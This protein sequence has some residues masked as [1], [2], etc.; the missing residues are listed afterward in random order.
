MGSIYI[1]LSGIYLPQRECERKQLNPIQGSSC[2]IRLGLYRICLSRVQ[3]VQCSQTMLE[4]RNMRFRIT[5][6]T[7]NWFQGLL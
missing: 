3:R 6:D 4:L 7:A 2:P 5:I 1:D